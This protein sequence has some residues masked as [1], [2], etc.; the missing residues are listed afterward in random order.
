MKETEA[1]IELILHMRGVPEGRMDIC[2]SFFSALTVPFCLLT[3]VFITESETAQRGAASAG[4]NVLKQTES[5]NKHSFF[6]FFIGELVQF[7]WMM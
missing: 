4:L 3:S 7:D 6:F 5:V 2:H 1:A